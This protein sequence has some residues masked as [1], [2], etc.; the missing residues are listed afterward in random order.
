MSTPEKLRETL[1]D[2]IAKH[3]EANGEYTLLH[4][5]WHSAAAKGEEMCIRDRQWGVFAAQQKGF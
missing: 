2:V 1:A 3:N 5:D 4:A